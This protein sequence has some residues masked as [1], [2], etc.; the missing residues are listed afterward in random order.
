[1]TVTTW[2]WTYHD[3]DGSDIT[4]ASA[5][6]RGF[7]AQADAETWVGESWQELL[8]EGVEAVTLWEGDS[9]VYGPMSLRPA[10]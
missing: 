6:E 10:R 7:P 4:P 1:M 8:S 5:P 2:T 3:A 9:V